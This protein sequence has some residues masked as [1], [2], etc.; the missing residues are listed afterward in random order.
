MPNNTV[1][2]TATQ[3][4]SAQIDALK[5]QC[6]TVLVG[7][8]QSSAAQEF[9]SMA[10]FCEQNNVQHDVYGDGE[11]IQEFEQKIAALLGFQAGVFCITGTMTQTLALRLACQN[12]NAPLVALHPS[13]HILKH[14]NSNYQ[15]LDHFKVQQIGAPNKVLTAADFLAVNDKLGA[16]LVELPMREIGGQLIDLNELAKIKHHCQQNDIHLHM[17]GARLWEAQAAYNVPF[18]QITTGFNSVYVSFYKGINGLAGA[19]LLGDSKFVARAK[20]WMH[21]MGGSVFRR[22]PYVISAAMQF[23]KRLAAMAACFERTKQIAALIKTLPNLTL[24]P[25]EPECNMFHLYL[26]V[27]AE[28]AITIRNQ[29][30][31]QHGVWLFNRAATAPLA[32]QC[33]VEIMVGDQLLAMSDANVLAALRLL[34][35]AIDN[36]KAQTA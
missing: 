1:I 25:S 3:L 2:N 14:E 5:Q 7:H 23:D 31:Q 6:H 36:V 15:L 9:A 21:R 13:A 12:R 24:N 29:I 4:S 26:P 28:K 34:N 19:M 20:T 32:N 16:A 22:S 10:T 30:A 17:D 35:G 8:K 18:T 11:F 33:Y 27:S